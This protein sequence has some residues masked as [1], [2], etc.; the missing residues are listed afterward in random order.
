M[1]ELPEVET[2]KRELEHHLIGETFSVPQLYYSPL[3]KTDKDDFL[4]HLIGHQILSLSR[5]GKFLI[6]HLSDKKKLLFHLRM[7]G[8]LYIEEKESLMKKHLTLFLPFESSDFGL[9]FYDVRKFGCLY[10]LSEDEG[11]PLAHVGKEPFDIKKEELIPLYQKDKRPI[12]EVLTDQSLMSGIGNIYADEILFA[13]KI[14]PF[15]PSSSLKAEDIETLLFQAK[16]ILT[17]AIESKGSTVRTY[18]AS[19]HVKGSFQEK[20][21]VYG[22]AGQLCPCCQ[23]VKIEKHSL[24]GR[25]TSYCPI[26]QKAGINV[27]ITGKIASGK[28][29]ASHYFEEEGFVRF[30]AD[31]KIHELYHSK[32]FLKQLKEKFPMVFYRGKLKKEKI[33]KLLTTDKVFHHRYTSYLFHEVKEAV[34][35]FIIQNDGKDKIFEIPLLFD[36]HM[37]KDFTYL[38]GIETTRQ[39][40]H[41]K[42]RGENDTRKNFNRLNSYDENK[43]KLNYILHS[44]GTKEEL[45]EQVKDV[46]RKM[47]ESH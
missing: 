22:K 8:K 25:G 6:F 26:C 40:E 11:G 7:E 13:S 41:L 46:I 2:V 10:Y 24:S 43:G 42:E 20:L 36:A 23:K 37:E 28:S 34:N 38:I 29:L 1:P 31:E 18:Q 19:E 39:S 5:K 44:D 4:S 12:K 35:D 45:H 17:E 16:R 14:S 32:A 33:T 3:V 15:R 47:K 21:K 27:A 9:A 30:S